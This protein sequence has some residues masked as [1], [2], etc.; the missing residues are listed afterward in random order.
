MQ[1]AEGR[2]SELT[3][4]IEQEGALRD[5]APLAAVIKAIKAGGDY[6]AKI[7]AAESEAQT[8][9][10]T[11]TTLLR[12]MRPTIPAECDIASL[13]VPPPDSVKHYRDRYRDLENRLHTCRGQIHDAELDTIRRE[14]EYQRVKDDQH[15]IPAEEL[16]DLRGHR[17]AGW[18]LIRR[19]YVEGADISEAEVT[20]FDPTAPLPEAYE[21]AV[22]R[23]DIAA[24][25]RFETAK[26]TAHLAE[27]ARQIAEQQERLEVLRGQLA[28]YIS[29][30]TKLGDEWIAMWGPTSIVPLSPDE[31]LVWLDARSQIFQQ[32][33]LKA[34]AE[35]KVASLKEEQSKARARLLPEIV[36]L[37]P[38][39]AS[40]NGHP[41]SVLIELAE[42]MH[43]RHEAKAAN[44][45]KLEQSLG[46]ATTESAA[47]LK[48][49]LESENALKGATNAW[50]TAVA[51]LG[52]D[53]ISSPESI[54]AQIEII[55]EMRD[56]ANRINDLRHERV[57]KIERDIASFEAEVG[58]LIPAVASHLEGTSAEDAVLKLE[59]LL[60]QSEQAR[61]AAATLEERIAAEQKKIN[62]C[63]L[64]RLAAQ[65]V[66]Q[67]LQMQA[68]VG[69]VEDLKTAIDHSNERRSLRHDREEAEKAVLE[70]GDGLPLN[71]LVDECKSA[72]LDQIA[73]RQ[74]TIEADLDE[75]RNQQVQAGQARAAAQAAFD[76]IGGDDRMARAAADRQSALAEIRGI[77]EDY[78]RLRSAELLLQHAIERYRR[79]KQGPLLT[80]AGQLFAILTG[81]SFKGLRVEFDQAD[82]M[83]IVGIR[84]SGHTVSVSG[85]TGGTVDQLYLALRVAAVE[86][87][88]S[89]SRPLPFIAD[90]LFVNFDDKRAAA[91]FKVLGEL[92]QKTQVLFFTHHRHLIEVADTA[93]ETNVSAIDLASMS[94]VNEGVAALAATA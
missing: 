25:R 64:E 27:I 89:R 26:A 8:A 30:E 61:N 45:R 63:D 36:A 24:D 21:G 74:Q 14:K 13:P 79:E 29:E 48:S 53:P 57:E 38:D 62:D 39:V 77:A 73:A 69:T 5:I 70:D 46:K 3:Q 68:G 34:S 22:E 44:R 80:R 65:R 17:D 32:L 71:E 28:A 51:A 31:M 19:K 93:L 91:G 88:L 60:Q 86:D 6:E 83:E 47:K 58:Q 55:G 85:M 56:T 1:E 78:I 43:R 9:A 87:Y 67:S 81:G 94:Q 41:L 66:V 18:S 15:A 7:G 20:A 76:A 54:D 75:L 16:S 92:A 49:V 52:L 4:E 50:S 33:Q 82:N 59:E 35:R 40:L 37:E 42:N 2:V 11:I 84:P 10:S 12:P 72:N 90:D 23:A